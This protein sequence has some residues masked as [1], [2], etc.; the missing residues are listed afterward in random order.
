MSRLNGLSDKKFV[1]RMSGVFEH[2]DWVAA[3][4]AR[5]RPFSSVSVLHDAM[6]AAVR[7][8]PEE[9]QDALIRAHPDL[10]GKAAKAGDLT[11]A[12]ASEQA[13]AGLD[14]MTD[15]QYERFDALNRAYQERFGFPFIVAVRGLSVDDI[16]RAFQV[17][18]MNSEQAERQAA[19]EQIARIARFR[20]NDLVED[21]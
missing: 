11:E 2:S 12:S 1:A 6:V 7:S 16:L 21:S 9:R 5:A 15:E 14:R 8:A 18:L 13:G 4:I 17:R 10:A 20:L 3:A 19:L